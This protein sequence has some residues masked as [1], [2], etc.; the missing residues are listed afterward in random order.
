MD[1]SLNGEKSNKEKTWKN[2]FGIQMLTTGLYA[3]L[4]F[5]NKKHEDLYE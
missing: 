5:P 4:R 2:D 3:S 1:I